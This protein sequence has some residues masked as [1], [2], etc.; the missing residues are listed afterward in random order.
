MD[1]AVEEIQKGISL[2]DRYNPQ[3][4][5]YD[6]YEAAM[7]IFMKN[8]RRYPKDGEIW[9]I[10]GCMYYK[11]GQFKEAIDAFLKVIELK[12]TIMHK[13]NLV[14]EYDK[15][16]MTN[17]LES[18]AAVP[19]DENIYYLLAR[20]YF[21]N[22]KY[23]EA[24]EYFLKSIEIIENEKRY[25]SDPYPN[26]Y[27]NIKEYIGDA[28]MEMGQYEKAIEIFK[29]CRGTEAKLGKAYYSNGQFKEAEEILLIGNC[30]LPL[31]E[32]YSTNKEYEKLIDLFL[33]N[34]HKF[35]WIGLEVRYELEGLYKKTIDYINNMI[36]EKNEKLNNYKLNNIMGL[37]GL[38]HYKLNNIDAAIDY[39]LKSVEEYHQDT[40]T[41]LLLGIS[42][43]RQEKY[44]E[45][46]EALLTSNAIQ[47]TNISAYHLGIAYFHNKQYEKAI[48]Y[49][50]YIAKLPASSDSY[51]AYHESD[52]Y[53]KNGEYIDGRKFYLEAIDID[54]SG[55]GAWKMLGMSYMAIGDHEKAKKSLL[56]ANK[57]NPEDSEIKELL[58][59]LEDLL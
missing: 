2:Y 52:K 20:A 1:S 14:I 43:L 22:C 51:L 15:L 3:F 49:L 21:K 5:N 40:Y 53:Y 34:L 44:A 24:I 41:W 42:Y 56:K 47:G 28:Y 31:V 35:L 39:F 37:L 29:N 36:E 48:K 57:L 9:W 23:K 8:R 17:V 50:L 45:G 11:K 19:I 18:D 33:K 54:P 58:K 12:D 32:L 27:K 25:K 10:T 59:K 4:D 7:D 46:L 38:S 55:V 13:T 16:W 6:P 26:Y 30:Y